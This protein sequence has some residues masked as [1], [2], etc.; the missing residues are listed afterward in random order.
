MQCERLGE[1][2]YRKKNNAESE[3]DRE[4][5]NLNQWSSSTCSTESTISLTNSIVT[6]G[7]IL[8]ASVNALWSA[9]SATRASCV[10]TRGNNYVC[11]HI[12]GVI[13]KF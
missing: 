7:M 10:E 3:K 2:T 5:Y 11:N 9:L 8:S 6:P 4:R 13:L 12:S 1:R